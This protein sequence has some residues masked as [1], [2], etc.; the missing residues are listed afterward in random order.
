MIFTHSLSI[1]Q[2]KMRRKK[3]RSIKWN[4]AAEVT[5]CI[6]NSG[7][8]IKLKLKCSAPNKN[9]KDNNCVVRCTNANLLTAAFK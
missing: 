2:R 8:A 6:I 3:K 4:I 9:L 7:N 1:A 5:Q